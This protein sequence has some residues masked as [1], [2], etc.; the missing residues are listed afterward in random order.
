MNEGHSPSQEDLGVRAGTKSK[1]FVVPTNTQYEGGKI[2]TAYYN[3]NRQVHV[4]ESPRPKEAPV[5]GGVNSP[6]L[7]GGLKE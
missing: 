4:V 2:P 5:S 6:K 3:V 1:D 7:S